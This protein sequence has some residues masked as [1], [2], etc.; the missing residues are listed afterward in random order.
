[1]QDIADARQQGLR[2]VRADQAAAP[3]PIP[4]QGEFVVLQ[5]EVIDHPAQPQVPAPWAC[6]SPT[7]AVILLWGR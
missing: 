6:P 3:G 4:Q 7:P 1:M 5:G 2:K